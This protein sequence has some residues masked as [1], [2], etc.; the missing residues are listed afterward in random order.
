M[1]NLNGHA[2]RNDGYSQADTYGNLSFL[3][4]IIPFDSRKNVWI[5]VAVKFHIFWKPLN[6]NLLYESIVL[7]IEIALYQSKEKILN[8]T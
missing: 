4:S 7:G 8:H 5:I 2:T 6:I 3:D 1:A